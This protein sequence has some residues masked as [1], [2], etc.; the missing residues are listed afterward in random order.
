MTIA[1]GPHADPLS[2]HDRFHVRLLSIGSVLLPPKAWFYNDLRGSYWR[3]Y[4][5]SERERW[6]GRREW[7]IQSRRTARS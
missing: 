1:P 2:V 6:C 4:V 3:L 5:N 7:N